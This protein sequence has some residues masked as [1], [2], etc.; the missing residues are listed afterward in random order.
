MHN[1]TIYDALKEGSILLTAA[2][3]IVG[4][5]TDF[6][7][8]DTHKIKPW[9]WVSLVGIVISAAIGFVVQMNDIAEQRDQA[10]TLTTN[11]TDAL[12]QLQR[13]LSS[14]DGMQLHVQFRVPCDD[15]F[16]EFCRDARL[17]AKSLMG[18]E[19]PHPN[20]RH[21]PYP[22]AHFSI[23]YFVHLFENDKALNSFVYSRAPAQ[24]RLRAAISSDANPSMLLVSVDSDASVIL[25]TRFDPEGLDKTAAVPNPI[26]S[27]V[28][29][30]GIPVV[31]EQ[32]SDNG[33]SLP[34][35]P[36]LVMINLKDGEQIYTEQPFKDAREPLF[37]MY[38][39]VMPIQTDKLI[40]RNIL[41]KTR[42]TAG[43]SCSEQSAA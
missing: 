31:V 8:K 39:T 33:Q 15:G 22:N 3:G 1:L 12:V 36:I 28:D 18:E 29:L 17:K 30:S 10:N 2:F 43:A 32:L 26:R 20:W 37:H 19:D 5:S 41:R 25:H 42:N 27:R 6:R 14:L 34:L 38:Q 4:L 24:M 16:Q 7:D 11:T 13:S 23:F 40:F 21:W 9:G 35:K